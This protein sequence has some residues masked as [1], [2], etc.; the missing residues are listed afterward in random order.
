VAG[1]VKLR[2]SVDANGKTT[3]VQVIS[4]PPGYQLGDYL[5]KILPLFD[6]LPGYRN[7]RPTATTYT[8]TWW[9]GQPVGR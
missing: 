6:F 8:L 5:K 3:N 7:G 4:E 1:V 9:F 2:H